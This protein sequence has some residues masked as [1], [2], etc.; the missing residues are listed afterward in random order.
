MFTVV[1][2]S[3]H[4][5]FVSNPNGKDRRPI[6]ANPV[7]E[8]GC[9]WAPNGARILFIKEKDGKR[10]LYTVSP[11]GADQKIVARTKR[12]EIFARYSPG[13]HR[14]VYEAMSEGRVQ[15]FAMDTDRGRHPRQLTETPWADSRI[16]LPPPT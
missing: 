16:A 15:L 14:I 11:T 9:D 5:V 7:D 6:L 3:R 2:P 13:G 1:G 10:Q 12:N 8:T 4:D